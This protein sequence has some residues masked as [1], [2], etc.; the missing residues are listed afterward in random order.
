[1]R[2][3]KHTFDPQNLFNPGKIIRDGRFKIDRN[4]RWERISADQSSCRSSRSWRSRPRTVRSSAIWSNATAA[5]AAAR[6]RRPCARR[7]SPPARRS[8]PRADGPT[9]SGAAL[10]LRSGT[11]TIRYSAELEA[12]L[13]N[14]LVLQGLHPGMS[15]QREPRPAQGGTAARALETRWLAACEN[16]FSATSIC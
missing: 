16:V 7:S 14:C 11:A 10:E 15:V 12:A 6:K 4:L 1:M 9:R 8:C 5:A 13:S 3:I 2:E